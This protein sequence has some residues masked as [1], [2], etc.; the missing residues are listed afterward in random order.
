MKHIVSNIRRQADRSVFAR[1]DEA[2][3]R[4][5]KRLEQLDLDRLPTSSYNH[6]YLRRILR[7]PTRMLQKTSALLA[8][9][10][11]SSRIPL[12]EFVLV[13]YGAGGGLQSFLASEVGIGRVIYNDIYDVS[14][15]D[16]SILAA[17]LNVN[18]HAFVCG[19]IDE[20]IAYLDNQRLS[21]DA[22]I[23][24][25]V[26]EH[27][28]DIEAFLRKMPLLSDRL[29]RVIHASGANGKNPFLAWRFKKNHRTVEYEDRERLPGWKDRD[30]L[31]S[32]LE[33]RKDIITSRV[34]DLSKSEVEK[35]AQLTRGLQKTDIEKCVDEY[36]EKGDISYR[37]EHPTNTCDPSTGNWAEH[38][39]NTEWIESILMDEGFAVT[40]LSGYWPRYRSLPKRLVGSVLNV[41]IRLL[42]VKGLYIS[43]YYVICSQCNS[44]TCCRARTRNG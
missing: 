18:V 30:T 24:S 10:V 38:L 23:S 44:P 39:M 42:G 37:P 6:R 28:Y 17:V 4:L 40:T 7:D 33:V 26:I 35:L 32:F 13:D 20:L 19:N 9:A 22:I 43:P 16:A 3:E 15:R 14:C 29:Y 21:V 31:R 25:D 41:C 2:A 36:M 12:E 34:P 27:I 5:R 8:L 1:I 11:E